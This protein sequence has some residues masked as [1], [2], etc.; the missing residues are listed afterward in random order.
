MTRRIL[1]LAVVTAGLALAGALFLTRGRA[2]A[3]TPQP[4]DFS[5][6][7]HDAA[8]VSC[9]FCHPNALRSPIAGIPSVQRCMG[10]HAVIARL[11]PRILEVS[12]YWEAGEAI[13]WVRVNVQPDF[14]FFSHQPHLSAG[15][16]CE[17]CHG[18][19]GGMDAAQP[20]V[21]M[22]MGWC[23]DCHLRQPDEKVTRLTDCLA[24]HE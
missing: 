11:R 5:H 18:D 8:G 24:C 23:L 13:P 14:V 10:C 7:I 9:L 17:T 1:I 2:L 3:A 19:V 22:D 4:I 20:V 16:N 6:R 15:L 12:R 21:R